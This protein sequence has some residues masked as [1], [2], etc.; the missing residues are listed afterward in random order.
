MALSPVY[1]QT[2]LADSSNLAYLP[3]MEQ[4]SRIIHQ[5]NGPFAIMVFDEAAQGKHI[6][7]IYYDQMSVPMI[8]KWWIAERF[9]QDRLWGSD[10][11]SIGWSP[12]GDYLYVATASVYGNGGVFKLDL[13]KKTSVK[14]F[15]DEGVGKDDI[16]HTKIVEI[17]S[18][19]NY[20]T[21]EVTFN[22]GRQKLHEKPI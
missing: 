18:K 5:P 17:D 19:N 3:D 2:L 9:W 21:I 13:K 11:K 10:V 8:G 16:L 12:L 14:I 6:G 20:L 4:E 15:P 1:C 22:D 7:V